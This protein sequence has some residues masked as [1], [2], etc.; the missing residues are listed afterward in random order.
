MN[1]END[2]PQAFIIA[3]TK[4]NTQSIDS[5]IEAITKKKWSDEWKKKNMNS[6]LVDLEKLPE[7]VSDVTGKFPN[8]EKKSTEDY[9]KSMLP[10]LVDSEVF[11]HTSITVAFINVTRDF[12]YLF[13]NFDGDATVGDIKG[14]ITFWVP[15]SV[16]VD[17]KLSV[18]YGMTLND[19]GQRI[20]KMRK[21]AFENK[22]DAPDKVTQVF[23]NL[24]PNSVSVNAVAS[25]NL[26]DWKRFIL[27]NTQFASIDESKYILMNLARM[28]KMKWAS[29]FFDVIAE[30]AT[31]KQFGLDTI[32][33]APLAFKALRLSV[34]RQ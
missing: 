22:L 11:A 28:M 15:P 1:V 18:E 32:S 7:I 26:V 23:N 10:F 16:S 24:Y 13:R 34:K 20:E 8:R 2:M 27:K 5:A 29:L 25:G 17:E 12:C 19:L 30:D 33:A 31:G 3:E 14:D 6:T 9:N 21:Y 4:L